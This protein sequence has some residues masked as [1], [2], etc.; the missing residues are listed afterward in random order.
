MGWLS[1]ILNISLERANQF[2]IYG[3]RLSAIG[4]ATT[5]LGVGLLWWAQE[6]EI[7]IL[8]PT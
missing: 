5:V 4:A 6:L 3:S 8:N 1:D 2:Y 7:M